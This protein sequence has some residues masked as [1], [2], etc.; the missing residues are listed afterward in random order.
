MREHGAPMP[1]AEVEAAL[2]HEQLQATVCYRSG[3]F[4][5][6][7]I[8]DYAARL[9]GDLLNPPIPTYRPTQHDDHTHDDADGADG[10]DAHAS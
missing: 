8:H 2:A 5:L 7:R 9:L 1:R 4:G 6:A 10:R 3:D